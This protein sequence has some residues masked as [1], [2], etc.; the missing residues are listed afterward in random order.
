[1]KVKTLGRVGMVVSLGE[2]QGCKRRL[3]LSPLILEEFLVPFPLKH[4]DQ[5]VW[6]WN[7]SLP[8]IGLLET[9]TDQYL[10]DQRICCKKSEEI[11][12]KLSK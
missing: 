12:Q 10:I 3:G 9:N 8:A 7:N 1:M 4:Q 6:E 11:L 5:R 2:L